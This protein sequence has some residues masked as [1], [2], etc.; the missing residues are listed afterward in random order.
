MHESGGIPA[1]QRWFWTPEWQSGEAEATQQIADG[2]CSEA[3]TS[4]AE[5]FAA[6]DDESA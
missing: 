1:E 6:I 4:A 2:E 5:L 3:F